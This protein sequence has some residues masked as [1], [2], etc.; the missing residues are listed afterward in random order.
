MV[1][2]R[3][4]EIR[5]V[6]WT[7]A[8]KGI[9]KFMLITKVI[10]VVL[11]MIEGVLGIRLEADDT[12]LTAVYQSATFVPA[13]AVG[14]RRMHHTDHGGWW[15]VFPF[16]NLVLSLREGQRGPNRFGSDP[17]SGSSDGEQLPE[18]T[19]TWA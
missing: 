2:R 7:S 17:I 6:S 1:H 14:V 19:H 18:I 15:L 13:I 11:G 5:R 12:V 16:V 4:E 9:L 8:A 3:A 10:A